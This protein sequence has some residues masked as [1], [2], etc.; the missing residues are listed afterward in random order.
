[1]A[2][3]TDRPFSLEEKVKGTGSDGSGELAVP[4][5][6]TMK[7]CKGQSCGLG[8]EYLPKPTC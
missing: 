6:P 3:L 4:M 7:G 8:L 1:M 2:G 5:H